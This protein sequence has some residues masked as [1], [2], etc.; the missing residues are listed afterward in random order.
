MKHDLEKAVNM[1]L[2]LCCF[3]QL[4]GLKNNFPKSEIDCFGKAKDLEEDY[5]SIFRYEVGTLPF[6]YHGPDSLQNVA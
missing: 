2:I 6:K 4:S 5:K 1:K 3:E